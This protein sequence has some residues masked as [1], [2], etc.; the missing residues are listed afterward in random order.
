[1]ESVSAKKIQVASE[2]STNDN[3]SHLLIKGHALKEQDKSSRGLKRV[4]P[5]NANL[6]NVCFKRLKISH[7]AVSNVNTTHLS[8]HV[9]VPIGTQWQNNSCAYDAI[10]MVL[11]NVWCEDPAKTM[12]L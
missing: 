8:P 3:K 6:P 10:C 7:D 11:F 4:G 9:L 12:L 1:V 2:S 5:N